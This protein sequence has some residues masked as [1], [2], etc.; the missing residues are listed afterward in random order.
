MKQAD[1]RV[2]NEY[3][4][5]TYQ[6]YDA[7]PLAARVRVASIDGQGKVTV[8]VVDPGPKPRR[9][10]GAPGRS[11]TTNGDRSRRATCHVRG[12]SGRIGQQPRVPNVRRGQPNSGRGMTNTNASRPIAW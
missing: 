7:A 3:A 6:P 10:P 8:L 5:P 1:L 2:G 9:M 11:R 12:M 4:L